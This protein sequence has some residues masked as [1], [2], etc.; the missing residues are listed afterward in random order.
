MNAHL[1]QLAGKPVG[2]EQIARA[3]EL[4]G[5]SRALQQRLDE[6]LRASPT[7]GQML[8]FLETLHKEAESVKLLERTDT[9]CQAVGIQQPTGADRLMAL[10]VGL[11]QEQNS[12]LKRG[13]N[14]MRADAKAKADSDDG[15]ITSALGGLI[16][17]AVLT[18]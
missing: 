16:L 7:R 12:L 2:E 6:F 3:R 15:L 8:E 14:Q 4:V 13:L 11:I 9:I 18:R 5:N 17:G 1:E 10:Q